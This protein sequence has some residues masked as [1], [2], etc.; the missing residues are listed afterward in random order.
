M[1]RLG[2]LGLVCLALGVPSAG[3]ALAARQ[4]STVTIGPVRLVSPGFGYVVAQRTSPSGSGRTE[5]RLLL[6]D[7]GRWRNATPPALRPPAFPRDQIDGVDDVDFAGSR[8]GWLAAFDCAR[9]GVYLYRTSDGGR[10]WRSL[11]EPTGHSC[12]APAT[13]FLSFVDAR[14]GWLEPTSPTGPVGA[15]L[16]TGDGGRNWKH[17]AIGPADGTGRSLP[18]LAPIRFVTASIGWQGRC[19]EAR[20]GVFSTADG[21]RR[22]RHA[23]IPVRDG[24]FDVPWFHGRD[25][26]D[27]ATVGS[28]PI[29]DGSR[30]RAVTFSVTSDGG[31]VWAARSTRPIG[32]CPLSAYSTDLWPASVVNGRIWWIVAGLDRPSAQVTLDGGRTWRIV[33]AHGLPARP[34]SVLDVSAAGPSDAWVVAR[35]GR[36]GTALYR[37]TDGGRDWRRV[38][39]FPS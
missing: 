7:H 29:G 5:I 28:R 37:T 34:C 24:R 10:S 17:V 36:D 26:V 2:L 18:C 27:A 9:A 1:S 13:T 38:D 15:L 4:S 6:F 16:E 19:D 35:T 31:R 14:H 23:A 11:G 25:G 20:G 32:S 33:A 12:S 22:W 3:A 21:G 30:T 8:D 39:L